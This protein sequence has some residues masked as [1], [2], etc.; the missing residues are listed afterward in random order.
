LGDEP[1]MIVT[2]LTQKQLLYLRLNTVHC[3][4]K[5]MIVFLAITNKEFYY[6]PLNS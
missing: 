3:A 4:I 6:F 5:K 1:N 2:S